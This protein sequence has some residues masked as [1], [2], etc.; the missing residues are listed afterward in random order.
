[1]ETCVFFLLFFTFIIGARSRLFRDPGT[2]SHT[3]FGQHILSSAH[4]IRTDSFSFTANGEP[5]IAQQWI[6]ECI[7]AVVHKLAGLDGLL[8]LTVA[9]IAFLYAWVARRL[10]RKGLHPLLSM[11]IIAL[12]LAASTQTFHV[13]PHMASILFL[14]FTFSRLCDFE[15]GR[16]RLRSLFWLI[17]L[18]ALWTNIHGG[19]LGGLGTIAFTFFGWSFFKIIGGESPIKTYKEMIILGGLLGA[20]MLTILINPYGSDMPRAWLSIMQSPVISEIIQEHGSLIKTNAWMILAFGIFYIIS[21]IGTFP[22]CPRTKWLI[23]LA[24]FALTCSRVRHGPLFAITAAIAMA[25]MFPHVRWGKWLSQKGSEICRIK[26]ID[27]VQNRNPIFPWTIPVAVVLGMLVYLSLSQRTLHSG[28]SLAK[29][30]PQHW[31]IELLPELQKYEKARP[32]GTPIFN[33]MLFG[34]FLIYFTPGLRVF[35][36]DRCEL[37]GDGRLLA[38]VRA[39]PSQFEEWVQRHGF[40]IALTKSGSSFDTYLKKHAVWRVVKQTSAGTLFRRS[41]KNISPTS[42]DPAENPS[43]NQVASPHF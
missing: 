36:D 34:G 35:I 29:L 25:D 1:M 24:W 23:P 26:P 38:Y 11:L 19:M 43:Q 42:R 27:Y 32:E 15:V 18:C 6:A 31:P 7:M 40:D 14:G 16:A 33:D 12:A 3:T 5:W 10:I 37:Y 2:F 4:L 30:D 39:E 21:L 22:K 28:P 8:V 17:P 9:A 13:R 20:C 41:E